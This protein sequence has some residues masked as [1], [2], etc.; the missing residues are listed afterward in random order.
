LFLLI[1]FIIPIVSAD[2]IVIGTNQSTYYFKTGENAI[3]PID[4]NNTYGEQIDGEL[5]YTITQEINQ[6]GAYYTNTNT[7][8]TS[9]S[10]SDGKSSV[11]F[12]FGTSDSPL[13][14]KVILTFSYDHAQENRAVILEEIT[15][16]FVSD[17]TEMNNEENKIESSSEQIIDSQ[18]NPQEQQP[19]T[20]QQQ[21]QNSQQPQDSSAIKEQMEKQLQEQQQMNEE[22]ENNLFNNSDFQNQ[23]QQ[24]L[25][26]GYNITNQ[27]FNPTD[28]NSGSF[29]MEYENEAGEKASLEGEMK[30][31]E[32]E[33]IRKQ[34]EEDR[35]QMLDQL[36]QNEEFQK[37]HEQ[38][39]M[40]GFNQTNIEFLQ[41][42]NNTNIQI[43]YMDE[44]NQTAAISAD[45]IDGVLQDVKLDKEEIAD[46][47]N[48]WLILLLVPLGLLGYYVY[49]KYIEK[50]SIAK[51]TTI[52]TQVKPFD[53]SSEANSR[54]C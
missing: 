21:L 25:D 26:Q 18:P 43:E 32:I 28:N 13:T 47:D 52:I 44:N 9:F 16:I 40:D 50:T 12:D 49:K 41:D 53:Y 34:T 35:Q 37:L 7:Q 14:L 38:L 15:I 39:E 33:N 24:L 3:I 2:D 19:Q 27:D 46:N 48:L 29:S 1:L 4:L 42:G 10:I 6:G 23:H 30:D 54:A 5:K 36:N 22:F 8:S 45:F 51:E 31:G 11:N 20:P 17:E